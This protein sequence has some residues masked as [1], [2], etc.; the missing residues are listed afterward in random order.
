MTVSV[1][2]GVLLGLA[3]ALLLQHSHQQSDY[4]VALRLEAAGLVLGV[5][6]AA[7][8]FILLG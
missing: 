3:G 5:I 8:L 7:L 1:G 6:G 2:V 4:M